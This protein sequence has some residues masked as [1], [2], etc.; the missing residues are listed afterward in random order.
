MT[1]DDSLF[2]LIKLWNNLKKKFVKNKKKI[3]SDNI[4]DILITKSANNI[5][6]IKNVNNIFKK[7]NSFSIKTT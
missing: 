2:P 4:N 6:D 3:T 7:N 5:Y 1:K